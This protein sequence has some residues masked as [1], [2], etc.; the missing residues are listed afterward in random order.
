MYISRWSVFDHRYEPII[1]HDNI[2][3]SE[4]VYGVGFEWVVV[5]IPH[6]TGSAMWK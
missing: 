4:Y 3:L 5:C 2:I 1:R 6:C